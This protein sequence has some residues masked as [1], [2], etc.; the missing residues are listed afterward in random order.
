VIRLEGS[1][2]TSIPG[3]W[4]CAYAS[5]ESFEIHVGGHVGESHVHQNFELARKW[6]E[7]ALWYS[8]YA[9]DPLLAI[10]TSIWDEKM[11]IKEREEREMKVE[12]GEKEE[13][14][15]A[16]EEEGVEGEEREEEEEGE[17]GEAVLESEVQEPPTEVDSEAL[18]PPEDEN[19]Y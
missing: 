8:G 6:K 9:W 15:G 18:D 1:V 13:E 4:A 16:V 5:L 17:E 12:G 11:N 14:D 2:N 10:R 3:I 7:K 19:K